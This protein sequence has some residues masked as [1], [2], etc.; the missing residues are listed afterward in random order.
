MDSTPDFLDLFVDSTG[1]LL[2][3]LA[4]LAISQAAL[5]MALGQRLR[6][7]SE[8]AA[9][10]FVV[11]L[12]GVVLAWIA[13]MGGALYALATDTGP[14][15]ILPPLERAV[16]TLVIVFTASA[17]LAADSPR[18]QPGAWRVTGLLA[19][20]VVAGY[21][22]TAI[23]WSPLAETEQFNAHTLGLVWTAIPI[24]LLV[25]A[26][27]LLLT[28]Y[29]QTADIPLKLV[30]F[31]VLLAA[32]TY[33][34]AAIS[35]GALEGDVSG[36]LRLG[37]LVAMPMLVA[38]IYRFVVD[39]LDAAIDEVSAYAEAV[40]R[41]QP[42]VTAPPSTARAA[43]T[44]ALGYTSA[45]ESVTLLRALGMMLDRETPEDIPR[46]IV[47]AVATVLKAD[48]AVLLAHDDGTWAD[49]ISAY[50]HIQA[51]TISGL[52]LNLE[53]QSTLVSAVENKNQRPLFPDRNLDEL[54]DL[55]TRLDINQVG[56]AYI[57]PLTR[58]GE[59]VGILIAALPYTS[60]ELTDVELNLLEGLGPIAARLLTMSRVALRARFE[61]ADQAIQELIT[62]GG[63]EGIDA[64]SVASARHTMQ[65]SLEAAQAQ[66]A[67]L[68]RMVRDL[69]VELDYERSR[70]GELLVSGDEAL[71][72]SQRIQALSQERLEL[73]TQ[74]QMLAHALQEAQTTL[75]SAT[76]EGDEEAYAAMLEA[77]RRERDELQV[78][79]AKLE[80]QLD[81]VRAAHE[82]TGPVALSAVVAEI[83]G[84]KERLAA[85]RDGLQ[86]E[87]E[88]VQEQLRALGI[89]GD[90]G[91]V[92]ETLTRLNDERALFKAR[93]EKIAQERDRLLAE[94]TQLA[95]QIEHEAER[96]TKL[97]AL[98][99]D[100]RRLATDRE[101]LLKQ[102]DATR[103]ERD[104][105]LKTRE[106]WI[107]QRARLLGEVSGLQA[108]L[109][110]MLDRMRQVE[111]NRKRIASER[112]AFEAERDRL[113][114]ERTALQ[115]ERDTL[116]ARVEGN[117]DLLEQLGA[118]GVG[119]LKT[120]ID[121][122][123]GERQALEDRLAETE[124]QL[125]LADQQL[126]RPPSGSTTQGTRPVAPANSDVIMSIAQ[127]LRTPMSSIMGYTDLLLSESIGILGA[128]QRQF[129]QRVQANIN[130]LHHLIEDL[131]HVSALDSE[132]FRLQTSAIDMLEVIEDAISEA[133]TQF[134]EKNITL[135]MRLPDALPPVR[136]DRD[137]MH[138]VIIQL[139]SNAYLASPPQGEV[140]LTARDVRGFVPP[141]TDDEAPAEEPLDAICVV[142]TDQGGGVPPDEQRRVFGRLYRADNP[143]IEGLG[144]TG[145]GLSIAKALVEA[146]GGRIWLESEPGRGSSF[147]FIVPLAAQLARAE[148]S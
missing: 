72:I 27:G 99:D 23:T 102:R 124:R 28:R 136:A 40:S 42:A 24:A 105:L 110:E 44:A 43:R 75:I 7:R 48:V 60:R 20:A 116:L 146:H 37:F 92:A 61:A 71:T 73:A 147:Q 128:L 47:E 36:A 90:P 56:P 93:A 26:V 70:L 74:R 96:Q 84:E 1:E 148:E 109:D 58:A 88:R 126:N 97:D 108:E 55:Y 137:A 135:H 117:R 131:V 140:T 118:D 3:F 68:N 129:L 120:M 18:P 123:T 83:T 14:D 59:V 38:I 106:T 125:A 31:L 10:R 51:R 130:R 33:T 22:Y 21:V 101:A 39:R 89:E 64:E 45:S 25:G 12:A 115:T 63:T 100:L 29:R 13:L 69:Q 104:D 77:L 142:V 132:Q 66:I 65:T 80:R 112:A 8:T 86:T 107:A 17:L 85:E 113:I 52:A 76:G 15:A 127:E 53:E 11:L 119:A 98:E 32:Y 34:A 50:N 87:L 67:D 111:D 133:G 9:G 143:L 30:Y 94:R 35:A 144:D 6:G 139:L 138:Q 2:Y 103:A 114:G 121:D 79:R 62:S 5:L 49:V 78:Q 4:V 41:P 91:A 81:E 57:Q 145:V 122:L 134:R 141:P 82:G 16:N 19:V 46:Q 54:V 95:A